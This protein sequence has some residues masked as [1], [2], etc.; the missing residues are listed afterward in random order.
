M[1]QILANARL[2]ICTSGISI[3][4]GKPHATA[5]Q[6]LER[7]SLIRSESQG[8][9]LFVKSSAETNSLHSLGIESN[10]EIHLLCTDTDAGE[11]CAEIVAGL[12]TEMSGSKVQIH[13]I[14]GLQVDDPVKFRVQGI[15]KLFAKMDSLRESSQGKEIILNPTGGYKSVVPY[16]ILYGM[17]EKLRAVY[18]HE[19]STHLLDLPAIPVAY[20]LTLFGRAEDAI[21]EMDRQSAMEEVRFFEMI[22]NLA[23]EERD[24]FRYLIEPIDVGHV[25]LSVFGLHLLSLIKRGEGGVFLSESARKSLAESSGPA[26]DQ[27]V[28]MLNRMGSPLYRRSKIDSW[29]NL[30]G[31]LVH[32]PG[33]TAERAVYF[34]RGNNIYVC[35]LWTDH[36]DYR[37]RTSELKL[38]DFPLS[39]FTL[40]VA[41]TMSDES[42]ESDYN[43]I[44]LKRAEK[45]EAELSKLQE[46]I[47]Q[48]VESRAG[49]IKLRNMQLEYENR[50]LR[51][52]Q[53]AH[54]RNNDMLNAFIEEKERITADQ[55]VLLKNQEEELI[56]LR[57]EVDRLSQPE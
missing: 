22:P 33:N 2:V 32:K 9:D 36:D 28:F 29:I 34:E 30:K 1:A 23:Y 51:T 5:E 43:K 8:D 42:K 44:L 54:I 46:E 27:L 38:E 21:L 3:A 35:A 31:L 57:L 14:E 25:T 50:K 10:D 48:R 4:G 26:R 41:P 40:W 15:P 47:N 7:V 55:N 24:T 19:F 12:I 53:E 39:S 13:R 45:A 49:G 52:E 16:I 11:T 20:D 6:V 37:R 18:L 17:L 56:K